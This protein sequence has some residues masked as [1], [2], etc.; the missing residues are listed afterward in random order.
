MPQ[1]LDGKHLKRSLEAHTVLYLALSKLY[2]SRLIKTENVISKTDE[3]QT[4]NTL[5]QLCVSKQSIIQKNFE[6]LKKIVKENK[7]LRT[8]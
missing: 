2:H 5:T 3:L 8:V 6:A 7:I 1:I 4:V